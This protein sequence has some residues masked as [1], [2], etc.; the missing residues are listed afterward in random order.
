MNAQQPNPQAAAQAAEIQQ[1]KQELA[2][3]VGLLT[4][5]R[6]MAMQFSMLLPKR[7]QPLL[8]RV[9]AK[10]RTYGR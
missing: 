2:I 9:N 10:L 8:E 7:T 3:L 1:Y 6:D 4:E 5:I